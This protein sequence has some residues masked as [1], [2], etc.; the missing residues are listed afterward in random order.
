MYNTIVYFQH[1]NSIGGVETYEYELVKKYYSTKDITIFYETGDSN[2]IRRL[3]EF[4]RVV[5][6]SG[7]NLKCEQLFVNYG[8]RPFIDHCEAKEYYQVIHADYLTQG[9]TPQLDDR[10]T[11]ICVSKLVRDNFQILTGLPDEKLLVSYNPI[12]VTEE[13]RKPSLILGSFTRLTKEKGKERMRILAQK[14]D[15]LPNFHYLWLIYTNDTNAIPSKNVAYMSPNLESRNIMAACDFVVQLSD[16]EGYSYT[17]NEAK[18]VTR[19]LR[20]PFKSADEMGG[21]DLILNFDLSNI[22]EVVEELVRVYR[23]KGVK[24]TGYKPNKDSY[25]TLILNHKS[26]YQEEKKKM[27][28]LECTVSFFDVELSKTRQVG[29]IFEVSNDRGEAL[30]NHP[31]KIVKLVERTEPIEKIEE[32]KEEV[33]ESEEAKDVGKTKV[34]RNSK[35]TTRKAR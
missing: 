27:I 19:V 25:D 7:E 33:K 21:N 35:K 30:L 29:D 24:N 12:E 23:D 13:E 3:K 4:V 10:F 1:I 16:C 11:Y 31:M 14:L 15:S 8:F 28:K 22:D 5:K 9:L 26:N 17:I 6:W 32:V 34:K 2:Q 20:T 18:H